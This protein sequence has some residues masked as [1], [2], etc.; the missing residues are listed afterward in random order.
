[1]TYT[2]EHRAI[3]RDYLHHVG[4][5]PIRVPY[6]DALDIDPGEGCTRIQWTEYV[7]HADGTAIVGD[8]GEGVR[9][10]VHETIVRGVAPIEHHDLT[11]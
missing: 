1:M 8:D 4:I 5:D 10:D 2:C 6:D 11:P 7:F 9:T 3:V